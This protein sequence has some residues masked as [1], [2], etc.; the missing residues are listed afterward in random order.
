MFMVEDF[1]GIKIECD[2]GVFRTPMTE[3]LRQMLEITNSK[4]ETCVR[5]Y[6]N[7]NGHIWKTIKDST[8]EITGLI[9]FVQPIIKERKFV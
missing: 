2:N 8:H 7:Q 4:I 1:L 5:L 3:E 6:S 9:C